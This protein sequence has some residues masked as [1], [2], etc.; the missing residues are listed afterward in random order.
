[1]TA[2]SIRDAWNGVKKFGDEF[3]YTYMYY[4][5]TEDTVEAQVTLADTAVKA[6]AKFIIIN[7][8]QFKKSATKMF[9]A[10]PDVSFIIFDTVPID[11]DGNPI[12]DSQYLGYPIC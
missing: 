4:Q 5:P 10:Y 8:D 11:D 6:G 9:Q 2:L 12:L 7:S 3:G 1:M